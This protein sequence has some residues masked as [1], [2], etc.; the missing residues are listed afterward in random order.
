MNVIVQHPIPVTMR[1]NTVLIV[2]AA[3]NATVIVD[4][5]KLEVYVKVRFRFF[6]ILN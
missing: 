4:L 3:L 1:R 2:K 5:G 6:F